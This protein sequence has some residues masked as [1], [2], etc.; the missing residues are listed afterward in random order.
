MSL[1]WLD[2]VL[3]APEVARIDP[4]DRGFLLGDGVFETIRTARG[5]PLHLAR[6][7]ARLRAGAAALRI[8]LA[9][10]DDEIAAAAASVL[11]GCG[12]AE[13]A[14]RVTLTRGPAA[15]GV[16]PAGPMRPTLL[17]TAAALPPPPCPARAVV[18][19]GTRRNA[20]SPLSRIKSLNYLDGILARLEAA[21]RGGDEA[22]L[23]S[24]QGDVAETSAGNIFVVL[25]G[26]V[27]TPPV[28][29]GALP[30]IARALLLEAGAAVEGR[31]SPAALG[32]AEAAFISNSLG[33]REI[34]WIDG[35]ELGPAGDAVLG[36]AR[37]IVA[38]V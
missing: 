18:A 32:E 11:A 3:M 33:V 30:G 19:L 14:L 34:G 5:A 13:A 6:H 35:R 17:V 7:L 23:L 37:R 26:R 22:I 25:S 9:W 12:L 36:R 38:A 24:T 4:A 29:D 21:E 16:L 2:G 31:V 20:F 28:Q 15:R 10:R 8:P 1:L 27:V